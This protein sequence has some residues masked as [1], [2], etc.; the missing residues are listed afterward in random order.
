MAP[1]SGPSRF[2]SGD[3]RAALLAGQPAEPVPLYPAGRT[4]PRFGDRGPSLDAPNRFELRAGERAAVS[5]AITGSDRDRDI[6][7]VRTAALVA[8]AALALV[9]IVA[10]LHILGLKLPF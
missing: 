8:V 9:G 3:D 2:P 7:L 6:G 5:S 10:V 4:P 1:Y